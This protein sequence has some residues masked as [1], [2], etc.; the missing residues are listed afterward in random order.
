VRP[1]P[2]LRTACCGLVGLGGLTD[3]TVAQTAIEPARLPAVVVTAPRFS[4]SADLLPFGVSVLTAEEIRNSGVSTVNEAVMKLLGVPGRA[5]SYGGGDYALDLRGF[6]ATADSNQVVVIDG[7]R[8]SEADL[9]GTR[10]AGIP[11]DS[12]ARIEVI[13]G[14]SAVLYGEGSTGGVISIT[15]KAGRGVTRDNTAEAFARVGSYGLR[16]LRATAGLSKGGFSLDVSGNKRKADNHRDNFRSD[17]SGAALTAQWMN[18]WLRIGVRH[19]NDD[20]H[21]GLP[22][23]LT[24][25]QYAAN[26][27]QTNTPFDKAAIR[28]ERTAVFSEATRGDWHFAFDAGWREKS[29]RAEFSGFTSAYDIDAKNYSVRAKHAAPTG[30]NTFVIGADRTD[31]KRNTL[32]AFGSVAKQASHAI[33]LKDEVALGRG[34]RLSAGWREERIEKDN[35]S[36]AAKIDHAA[37]AWEIGAVQSLGAGV[38]LFGRVGHSF[39]LANVDE[40]GFTSP[41]ATLRPQTSRDAEIGTRWTQGSDRAELRVYRSALMDEIGFNPNAP[42]PFG[43]GANV[44]FDATRRQGI[45]AEM[46]RAW[47][48]SLRLRVNAALRKARFAAGAYAGRDVP[49]TPRRTLAV[50]ADWRP[51]DNHS[52][53]ALLSMV[54][55]QHPDFANACRM[56]GYAI[57]DLRYAYRF[58]AAEL[59]VGVANLT[60]RKFYTQAFGCANGQTMSIYPEP[61]RAFTA[62]LRVQF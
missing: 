26:P 60:D 21:T 55:S 28:N 49:L 9:G 23:A 22:G 46:S 35:S 10:L 2:I 36:T 3:I 59:A 56:P 13:R 37:H 16:E 53:D 57:A 50:G 30:S 8:V 52:V 33:Y 40:F 51:A 12:V 32:G 15:T 6:G 5:D 38:A 25:A 47:N 17:V 31:W 1:Y 29:S 44:N 7:V 11:I 20:L 19:A 14:G 43:P 4:E 58:R 24:A 34:T 27:R 45:E 41:G 62:S 18:D 48:A 61:G 54:S 42:G 39:R